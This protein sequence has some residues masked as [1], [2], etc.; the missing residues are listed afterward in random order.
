[1]TEWVEL[2]YGDEIYHED[3]EGHSGILVV[4]G[5]D[6]GNVYGT[7]IFDVFDLD[8]FIGEE[9]QEIVERIDNLGRRFNGIKFIWREDLE[10]HIGK[11]TV[12]LDLVD[13]GDIFVCN[14]FD[15]KYVHGVLIDD[16]DGSLIEKKFSLNKIEREA[17]PVGYYWESDYCCYT[18]TI[19]WDENI[20]NNTEQIIGDT[21]TASLEEIK[22]IS[23]YLEDIGAKNPE[24]E[25]LR[26]K[27]E[28]QLKKSTP[29]VEME[30]DIVI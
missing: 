12:I 24:L 25:K 18:L 7:F 3:N 10:L 26:E 5:F 21:D 6:Q 22:T 19:V 17:D 14:S 15:G 16:C 9:Q 28:D 30:N 23:K 8:I 2:S 27:R 4:E 11:G 29:K 13:N 20:N 1:M